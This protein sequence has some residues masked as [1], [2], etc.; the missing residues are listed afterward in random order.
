[1]SDAKNTSGTNKVPVY[2]FNIDSIKGEEFRENRDTG[3]RNGHVLELCE[4]LS[5]EGIYFMHGCLQSDKDGY[6]KIDAPK[7]YIHFFYS[8]KYD[9]S[10]SIDG[11]VFAKYGNLEHNILFFPAGEIETRWTKGE[12]M[13]FFEICVPSDFFLSRFQ[14]PAELIGLF[15]NKIDKKSAAALFPD[16][17]PITPEIKAVLHDMLHSKV[18]HEQKGLLLQAK[19]IELVVLQL[20]QYSEILSREEVVSDLS[21]EDMS[22]MYK[23]REIILT[24]INNPYSLT[25]LAQLVG[26]NETYFK[27]HFKMVFGQTVFAYI[28]E[29]RMRQAHTIL[30]QKNRTV[31]EVAYFMGY[32]H[33]SHFSFAFK[34]HFGVSPSEVLNKME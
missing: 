4:F 12:K 21:D 15:R 5:E 8:I 10:Y 33:S 13:E 27:K 20:S 17:M 34:K 11:H 2:G 32:K 26:T 6:F 18:P 28:N 23:A 24:T 3:R 22:R 25:E 30:E 19:V 14:H 7:P 1:M 9:R 31:A 29:T 16:N